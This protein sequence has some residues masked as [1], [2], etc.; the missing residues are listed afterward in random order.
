MPCLLLARNSAVLA[1]SDHSGDVGG[2]STMLQ[3]L[4]GLTTAR[5]GCFKLPCAWRICVA[6][7]AH[8]RTACPGRIDRPAFLIEG[9]TAKVS[10]VIH[11]QSPGAEMRQGISLLAFGLYGETVA[12]LLQPILKLRA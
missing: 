3:R 1:P 7:R 10:S 4:A 6:S 2:F 9:A 11:H 8:P 5:W 12:R